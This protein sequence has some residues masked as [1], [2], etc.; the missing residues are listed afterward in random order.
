MLASTDTDLFL[1]MFLTALVVG[2]IC[3]SIGIWLCHRWHMGWNADAHA[4]S[5][6]QQQRENRQLKALLKPRREEG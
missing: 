4:E 1:A 5:L 3:M 2:A 6:H